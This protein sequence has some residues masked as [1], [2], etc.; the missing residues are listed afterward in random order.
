MGLTFN[1]KFLKIVAG[2]WVRAHLKSKK[3]GLTGHLNLLQ[4]SNFTHKK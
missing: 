4:S 2:I 3:I 1:Y